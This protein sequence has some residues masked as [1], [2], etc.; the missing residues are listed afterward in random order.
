[1][2]LTKEI[3]QYAVGLVAFSLTLFTA[4]RIGHLLDVTVERQVITLIG[5]ASIILGVYAMSLIRKLEWGAVRKGVLYGAIVGVWFY[6]VY[7][8]LEAM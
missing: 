1:M 7:L 5:A 2:T 3:F 6:T 8:W 4:V